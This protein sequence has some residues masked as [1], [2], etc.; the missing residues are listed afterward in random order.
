MFWPRGPQAGTVHG[1]IFEISTDG[2]TVPDCEVLNYEESSFN[3]LPGSPT[4]PDCI[5]YIRIPLMCIP[6]SDW[7]TAAYM[8]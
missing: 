1:A 2:A 5:I 3:H 7:F 4:T 6:I 8:T